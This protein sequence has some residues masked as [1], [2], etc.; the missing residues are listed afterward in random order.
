MPTFLWEATTRGG[1]HRSGTVDADT[2]DAVRGRL[3]AQGLTVT[4]LKKKPKE[5]ELPSFGSGVGLKDLV[6]F[7]RTFSTM[8]DAGLP[9]VQCLDMLGTQSDNRRFGKVLL[10]VKAEVESGKSLSEAMGKYPKVFDNLFRNLV[11]AGEAG[12]RSPPSC[13]ARFV[14]RSSTRAPS[15]RSEGSSWSS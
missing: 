13:V 9:I 6:I 5:L 14:A 2:E 7:T 3:T 12:S 11:A 15:S 4:G 1:E 10:D 8:I